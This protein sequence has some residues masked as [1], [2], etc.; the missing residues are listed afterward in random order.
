VS[1]RAYQLSSRR[2]EKQFSDEAK[3][4]FCYAVV[5]PMSPEQQFNVLF[6]ANGGDEA[7]LK[8][9]RGMDSE[10]ARR[11]FFQQ[12]MQSSGADNANSPSEYNASIQQ[13]MRMLNMDSPLYRGIKS[14]GGGALTQILRQFK[15]PEEIV[16]QMYLRTVSRVPSR[17]ELSHCLQYF[18]EHKGA[19]EAYEDIFFV[20]MN[21]NEF[22]FNH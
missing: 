15:K 17:E 7:A 6:R 11:G 16:T 4:Y 18:Q 22:Y 13:I 3:K 12:M 20:L 19:V 8:G 1:S 14:K 21:T 5:R 2:T 9:P 10:R